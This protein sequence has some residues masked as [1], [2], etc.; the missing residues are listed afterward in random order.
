MQVDLDNKKKESQIRALKSIIDADENER[1][2][3]S[4]SLNEN[5]A[6]MLAAVQLHISLAKKKIN[7]EAFIFMDEAE[8]ILKEA[9][10][11][12]KALASSISP[13][14]LKNIGFTYLLN[15]LVLLIE[16]HHQIKCEINLD[17]EVISFTSVST[18][19]ILYQV[20]Q[21]QII[22]ILKCSR[23]E[24]VSITIKSNANK[25]SMII[26]DDGERLSLKSSIES[27]GFISLKERIEAFDGSLVIEKNSSEQGCILEVIM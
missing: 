24:K 15:E 14:M 18:R 5:V 1:L 7:S 22:S 20:A 26:K 3:I 6:Q 21:L 10:W 27:E 25:V 11:E 23:L 13:F 16:D 2:D 19:N 4:F 8:N 17:E 12:I 9:I